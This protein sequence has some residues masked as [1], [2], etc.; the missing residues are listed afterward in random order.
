MQAG[1]PRLHLLHIAGR[2]GVNRLR[3]TC[4]LDA[5][6]AGPGLDLLQG[7]D[8]ALRLAL[9]SLAENRIVPSAV[10]IVTTGGSGS[11]AE[12]R[13]ALGDAEQLIGQGYRRN[14]AG[15]Y[16]EAE[17]FFRPELLDD[18]A[19]LG[20]ARVGDGLETVEENRLVGDRHQLLGRCVG[21]GA[22]TGARPTGEYE[23][24]HV[25]LSPY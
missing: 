10:D 22:Q 14:N 7:F 13:A 24:L 15:E 5:R 4:H 20:D 11:L 1:D 12:A 19:D 9:A 21:D 23:S 6:I 17:E 25:F 18:D 3:D 8:G 2:L 16:T